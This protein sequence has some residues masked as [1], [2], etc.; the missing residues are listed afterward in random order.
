MKCNCGDIENHDIFIVE[1]LKAD[2]DFLEGY[3]ENSFKSYKRTK[4]LKVFIYDLE[5]ILKAIEE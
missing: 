5:Y 3:I 4:N 2:K 1:E